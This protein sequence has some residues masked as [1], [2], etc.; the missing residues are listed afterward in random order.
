MQKTASIAIDPV[1]P[2]LETKSKKRKRKRED[3][4]WQVIY[5]TPEAT[6]WDTTSNIA[7]VPVDPKSGT[8]IFPVIR[9]LFGQDNDTKYVDTTKK[10]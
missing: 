8:V 9:Y 5:T 1:P 10:F 2:P 3:F 7:L 4:E 6:T